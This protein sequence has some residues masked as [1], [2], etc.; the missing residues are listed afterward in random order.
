MSVTPLIDDRYK[1]FLWNYLKIES[2][3]EFYEDRA[4]LAL[5]NNGSKSEQGPSENKTAEN[6]V[7]LEETASMD[8][9]GQ[10]QEASP[11]SVIRKRKA[12]PVKKKPTPKKKA[13]AKPKP[14]RK[15]ATKKKAYAGGSD[16]DFEGGS[17]EESDSES[18]FEDDLSEESEESEANEESMTEDEDD[19]PPVSKKKSS[20]STQPKKTNPVFATSLSSEVCLYRL[21]PPNKKL[22][23]IFL[24]E[25]VESSAYF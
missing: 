4:P 16:D 19:Q 18:D 21:D 8:D 6:D 3:L 5:A 14:K 1:S 20:K 13:K 2:D 10:Q 15:T 23:M 12:P 25:K 24:G 22:L 7:S 9:A 17:D 11:P